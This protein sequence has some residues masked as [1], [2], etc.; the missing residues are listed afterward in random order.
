MMNF[1]RACKGKTCPGC[2]ALHHV[3]PSNDE[4]VSHRC[5]CH[6]F[7]VSG[8]TRIDQS[9]QRSPLTSLNEDFVACIDDGGSRHSR[10]MAIARE[11]RENVR[12]LSHFSR[13]L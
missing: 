3:A 9:K 12:L 6:R 2:R 13:C 10:D 1:L 8:T 5:S 4:R 7:C 11:E